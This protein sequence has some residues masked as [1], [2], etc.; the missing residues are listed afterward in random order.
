LLERLTLIALT[1]EDCVRTIE[2]NAGL[3]I[4]GGTI[5][6]AL[7]ARCAVKAKAETIYTWNIRHYQLLGPNI[8]KRL[9]T[10]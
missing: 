10:P 2:D 7:L 4:V 9:S 8:T 5:Y 3:G 1:D 6:D